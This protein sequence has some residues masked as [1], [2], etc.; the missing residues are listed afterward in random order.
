VA[1]PG[2]ERIRIEG[3]EAVV[4][5]SGW[6]ARV[7]PQRAV[8]LHRL[9]EALVV[10]PGHGMGVDEEAVAATRSGCDEDH[11]GGVDGALAPGLAS[12]VAGGGQVTAGLTG[13]GVGAEEM[14][15]PHQDGALAGVTFAGRDPVQSR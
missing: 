3:S 15:E 4:F 2:F 1:G 14:P 7:T 6:G 10:A 12:V 13:I 5:L 9:D 8:L 11:A